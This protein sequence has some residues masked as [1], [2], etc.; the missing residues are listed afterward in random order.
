MICKVVQTQQTTIDRY[1]DFY[2][3]QN[4]QSSSNN[5]STA[6]ID[7][8]EIITKWEFLFVF[9]VESQRTGSKDCLTLQW[10]NKY[11]ISIFWFSVTFLFRF[12][13]QV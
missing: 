12:F 7:K 8:N 10:A 9:G 13:H 1:F 3:H 2:S 5:K 4:I 11:E 6:I